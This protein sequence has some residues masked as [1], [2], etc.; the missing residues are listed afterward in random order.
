MQDK[1]GQ[2]QETNLTSSKRSWW[3]QWRATRLLNKVN[4]K[5]KNI[6]IIG[7]PTIKNKGF[8]GIGD[9]VHINA[10]LV[11]C[12]IVVEAN[13]SLTIG[14]GCFINGAIIAASE[15][16]EIGNNCRLAP[17]AHIMD[18]DYH[19]L[20]DR[21]QSGATGKVILEDGVQL[22]ARSV[23]LKGV[24]IGRGAKVAPGAV[25]TQDVPAFAVVSGIPAKVVQLAT[26][27]AP[28]LS[29]K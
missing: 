23:V 24:R 3:Q 16:I 8:L 1:I 26:A 28:T 21:L 5:G 25:V 4:Q 9:T 27:S 20:H 12:R 6:Q 13:A 15:A 22:G 19:D 2:V 14:N 11:P 17:Y 10:E 7:K 18:S 29:E